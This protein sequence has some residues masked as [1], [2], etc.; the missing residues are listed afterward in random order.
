MA[1]ED[2]SSKD[3]LASSV[4]ERPLLTRITNPRHVIIIFAFP[5]T[6]LFGVGESWQLV[7]GDQC[8]HFSS[9][10]PSFGAN[11]ALPR[12]FFRAEKAFKKIAQKTVCRRLT[13]HP[14][15]FHY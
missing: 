5:N 2:R 4:V 8:C 15:Q 10:G 6:S 1:A 3:D 7:S 14:T 13:I 11:G 9:G 12:L